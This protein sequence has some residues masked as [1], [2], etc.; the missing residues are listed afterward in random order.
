MNSLFLYLG[1]SEHIVWHVCG[2]TL[3]A[4]REWRESPPLDRLMACRRRD[5]D[6]IK[7][8]ILPYMGGEDVSAENR[9]D[10]RFRQYFPRQLVNALHRPPR[11]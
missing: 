7:D 3:D 11:I 8:V 4:E 5:T 2:K 6:K 9:D 1:N 10:M